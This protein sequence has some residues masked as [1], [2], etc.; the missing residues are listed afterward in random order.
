[1]GSSL[2]KGW[3]AA[4]FSPEALGRAGWRSTARLPQT[5][6]TKFLAVAVAVAAAA[7]AVVEINVEDEFEDANDADDDND[8]DDEAA[9]VN[10]DDDDTV[11]DASGV[12]FNFEGNF[13]DG[14]EN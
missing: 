12:K 2:L 6:K 14:V 11:A 8:A 1:M 10:D 13:D 4:K 5:H 7:V 9:A 3:L